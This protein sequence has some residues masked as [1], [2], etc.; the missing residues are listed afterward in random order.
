MMSGVPLETRWVFKKNL[1]IINSVTKLHLVGTSTEFNY[2]VA[3]ISD[4]RVLGSKVLRRPVRT[5]VANDKT[6]SNVAACRKNKL[7][8]SV[9]SVSLEFTLLFNHVKTANIYVVWRQHLI[10]LRTQTKAEYHT[11][12]ADDQQSVT[13]AHSESHLPQNT[14]S[15]AVIFKKQI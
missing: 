8:I 4:T 7:H 13:V 11:A 15:T 5:R 6:A 12:C 9:T 2:C 10:I 3:L 14:L 1:G